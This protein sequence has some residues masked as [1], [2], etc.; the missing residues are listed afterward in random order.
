MNKKRIPSIIMSKAGPGLAYTVPFTDHT[1]Q[2][3][4]TATLTERILGV[5][6]EEER[7]RENQTYTQTWFMILFVSLIL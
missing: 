4:S 5:G 3:H 1:R 2:R 6:C 7:D